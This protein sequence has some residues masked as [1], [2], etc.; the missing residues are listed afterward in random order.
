MSWGRRVLGLALAGVLL[1][2]CPRA[3]ASAIAASGITPTSPDVRPATGSILFDGFTGQLF[4]EAR[5]SLGE[6]AQ[7]ES[8]LDP[9]FGSTAATVTWA[10]SRPFL[11]DG[12]ESTFSRVDLPGFSNQAASL[13]RGTC[14]STFTLI[15]GS[16][17]V[18]VNF[19]I[20]V[21]GALRLA[22]D[23]AGL[24]AETE[25]LFSMFVD[26]DPVLFDDRPRSIG[27][28]SDFLESFAQ[29]LT[30]ARDLEFGK[31][32]SLTLTVESKSRAI[33]ADVP[34]PSTATLLGLGLGVA[35]QRRRTRRKKNPNI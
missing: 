1:F 18:S 6:L 22:T 24:F 25:T 12:V 31:S 7:Y 13:A 30:G 29:T 35:L 28:N 33:N 23:S 34:E 3:L 9:C 20:G 32:Y 14:S 17:L 16:G 27:P 21:G 10:L 11:G 19:S 2:D 5:N 4:A 26:G 15:G 8:P